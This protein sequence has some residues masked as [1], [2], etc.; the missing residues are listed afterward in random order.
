MAGCVSGWHWQRLCERV[1]FSTSTRGVGYC[2]GDALHEVF[3]ER[4]YAGRPA[5]EVFASSV[6]YR[7]VFAIGNFHGFTLSTCSGRYSSRRPRRLAKGVRW[8]TPAGA[9]SSRSGRVAPPAILA[10]QGPASAMFSL[11]QLGGRAYEVW[12]SP[13]RQ[14]VV[15]RFRRLLLASCI[16]YF[17]D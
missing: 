15:P 8:M 13:Q 5:N 9:Q 2:A 3:H 12:L 1:G 11:K 17:G 4:K 10:L 7:P 16:S 14:D 6:H